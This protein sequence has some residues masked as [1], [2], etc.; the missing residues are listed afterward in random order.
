MCSQYAQLESLNLLN[1]FVRSINRV[2]T[3]CLASDL[4][5][6]SSPPHPHI[7]IYK[8]ISVQLPAYDHFIVIS[9]ITC[10]SPR[11]ISLS[12]MSVN[13]TT[14]LK[15]TTLLINRTLEPEVVNVTTVWSNQTETLIFSEP[16]KFVLSW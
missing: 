3:S 12:A 4:C 11:H 8:Y 9:L 7:Y 6:M 16:I 5:Y 14:S 15:P 10:P 2:Q 1:E 13:T